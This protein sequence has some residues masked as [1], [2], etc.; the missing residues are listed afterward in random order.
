[1]N[2]LTLLF[3]LPLLPLQ[4]F[5]KLATLISDEAEQEMANPVTIR[6]ELEHAER[7]RESGEISDEQA[8]EIQDAAFGEFAKARRDVAAPGEGG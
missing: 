6:H 3:R 7:A 8:A 4:G 5:L 2:L 1:M